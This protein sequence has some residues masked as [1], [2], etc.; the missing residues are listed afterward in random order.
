MNRIESDALVVRTVEFGEADV[1]ATLLTE[2]VGKIGAVVR[3]ARKGSRRVGGALEPIHTIAVHL[4][5]RGGD[6]ATLKEARI[7]RQRPRVT[8]DLDALGAAGTVL[9]WAR[10]LFPPRTPEPEGW[11][12]LVGLLDALESGDSSPRRALASAGLALLAAVGYG[13]E[14]ERCVACGRE[15]PDGRAAC[16]DPRRGGLLCR[17][18]GGAS[19]VLSPA[20]REGARALAE[21]RHGGASEDQADRVLALLD[22]AFAAHAGLEPGWR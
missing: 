12:V 6:L 13:L 9:R 20:E 5:D 8:T 1:V 22:R 17:A 11:R 18:C 15:C 7:V 19:D 21:G 4:E 2:Q 14:L 10:H 3:G 16:V